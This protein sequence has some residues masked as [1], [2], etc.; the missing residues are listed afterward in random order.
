MG[1]SGFFQ[2]MSLHRSVLT[3]Y[4]LNDSLAYV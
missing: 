2:K 1:L 3:S 4:R